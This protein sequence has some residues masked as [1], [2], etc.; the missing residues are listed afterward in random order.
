MEHELELGGEAGLSPAGVVLL[1]RWDTRVRLAAAA[2]ARIAAAR[3]VV[4]AHLDDA[5]TPVYGLTTG[6]GSLKRVRVSASDSV[7]FNAATI[8]D[9]AGAVGPFLAPALARAVVAVRVQGLA[10]GRAGVALDVVRTMVDMYNTGLAPRVRAWGSVGMSD[11]AVLAGIARTLLGEGE[12]WRQG[13][14]QRARRALR[15]AGIATPV[16]R[17]QDALGLINANSFGLTLSALAVERAA[18]LA[19]T[20]L[21]ALTFTMAALRANLAA[22][23]PVVAVAS[24]WRAQGEVAAR[25]RR[26]LA[27]QGGGDT[28]ARELQDP[29]SVRSAAHVHGSLLTALQEARSAVGVGLQAGSENP[30][31]DTEGRRMVSCGNFDTTPL[32]L[33]VDR[34]RDAVQR[35]LHLSA[36]RSG[37]LLTQAHSGLPTNL[38]ERSGDYGLGVLH[39][40]SAA[41]EARGAFPAQR[42]PLQAAAVAEGIEDY[43]TN[44][45][46]A[47]EALYGVLEA[48]RLA[49]ALEAY[50]AVT[51]VGRRQAAPPPALAEEFRRVEAAARAQGAHGERVEAVAAA[52]SGPWQGWFVPAEGTMA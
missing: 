42:T 52:L 30:L 19:D 14:V 46:L 36:R 7:R 33:A 34:L 18:G 37:L 38:S 20:S 5:A 22:L 12:V 48:W 43:G 17:A 45:P 51:A 11:L 25:L 41:L 23:D 24:G 49:I 16:P 44:L 21:V 27:S 29:I 39:H 15:A 2:A 10:A 1:T 3:E 13:R 31:V 9:H 26:L 28:S 35:C 8:R 47:A 32:V 50:V 4:L 6:V 40:V